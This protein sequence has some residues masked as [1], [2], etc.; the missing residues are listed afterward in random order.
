MDELNFVNFITKHLDEMISLFLTDKT[1]YQNEMI[2][3]EILQAFN[4]LFEGSVD[5]MHTVLQFNLFLKHPLVQSKF[6][7]YNLFFLIFKNKFSI[8]S[9]FKQ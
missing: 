1:T 7:Y 3:E 8:I 9:F 4:F 6:V 5:N 2:S